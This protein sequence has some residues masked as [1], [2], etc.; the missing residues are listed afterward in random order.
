MATQINDESVLNW[1]KNKEGDNSWV[2]KCV[3]RATSEMAWGDWYST[4]HSTNIAES[5]HAHLQR[6]G[7]RSTLVAAVEGGRRLDKRFLEGEHAAQ[8]M[9][10]FSKYGNNSITGWTAKKMKRGNKKEGER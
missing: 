5:A 7:T 8:T 9:G 10:V 4:S 3:S 2:L 6:D 1:L